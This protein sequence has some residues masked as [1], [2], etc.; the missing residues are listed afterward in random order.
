[1]WYES[2]LQSGQSARTTSSSPH[3]NP[4]PEEVAWLLPSIR[5]P[6]RRDELT[7]GSRSVLLSPVHGPGGLA[8]HWLRQAKFRSPGSLVWPCFR[9]TKFLSPPLTTHHS[10][11]GGRAR[12]MQIIGTA[13]LTPPR[14]GPPIR[15]AKPACADRF[16]PY[17]AAARIEGGG[18]QAKVGDGCQPWLRAHSAYRT[19]QH[20]A[21]CRLS[22]STG[23]I[24]PPGG[25]EVRSSI[26]RPSPICRLLLTTR[27]PDL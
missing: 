23:F 10:N 20:K 14:L 18:A 27:F 17:M 24:P 12:L 19:E 22:F 11:A 8:G 5:C 3:H 2:A 21:A 4:P 25:G 6:A 16:P 26:C 1:M 13:T 7:S 9:R 15:Q